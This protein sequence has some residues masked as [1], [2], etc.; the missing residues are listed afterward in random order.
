MW[1]RVGFVEVAHRANVSEF[2][3]VEAARPQF[4]LPTDPP[5]EVAHEIPFVEHVATPLERADAL[6]DF[7]D[8]RYGGHTDQRRMRMVAVFA[9]K[10]QCQIAAQRIPGN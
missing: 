6:A 7:Q 5:F 9:G 10:F 3:Q 8:W 2:R 4:L 1:R